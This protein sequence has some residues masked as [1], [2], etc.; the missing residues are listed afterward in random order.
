LPGDPGDEAGFYVTVTEW[1]QWLT[2]HNYA[3]STV[4]GRSSAMA[5]FANWAGCRGI[6][7]PSEVT[8]GVLEAYQRYVALRRKP[9][10]MALSFSTQQKALVGLRLFFA[11]CCRSHLIAS[12]PAAELTLPRG[13]HR[14]PKATLSVEEAEAVL[15]VP[16]TGTVI[17]LRDRT[18]LEVLYSTGMRRG[19][20]VGLDLGDVDLK[21]RFLTLRHTKTRW[22][23]VVPTG[24]RACRWLVR[25][26]TEARPA[27]LVG[28]DP[29]AVFLAANGE[30]LGPKWLS[31]QVHH[32]IGAAAIGKSGSCHLFRHT[33]A[34]L[35]VEGGADI[36]YVGELLGHRDLSSTK[37]YTRIS[38]GRLAAI[39]AA[40][41]PGATNARPRPA[42]GAPVSDDQV[43]PFVLQQQQERDSRVPDAGGPLS[44]AGDTATHGGID[45]FE[46]HHDDDNHREHRAGH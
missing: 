36:C 23:R 17:G 14:L 7:R 44:A 8:L 32:Y 34:T 39:H 11:W 2:V 37:L 10:G 20:L 25:Y 42:A 13:E 15:A 35:M 40:T 3:P 19:E 9:D 45:H 24:E 43:E 5:E 41:H 12:N 21:R 6:S 29:G 38:P 26:L 27:L 16:D 1:L 30:R 31:A 4:L 18:V 28:D 22:D 46:E 33:A